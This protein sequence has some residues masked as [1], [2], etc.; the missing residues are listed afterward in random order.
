MNQQVNVTLTLWADAELTKD[1]VKSN[2]RDLIKF[3]TLHSKA[4]DRNLIPEITITDIKEESEIYKTEPGKRFPNGFNSWIE[5]SI[6]ISSD[7]H[8]AWDN[9]E[10]YIDGRG[11]L[12]ELVEKYTDEF[13]EEHVN[14]EWADQKLTW[15]DHLDTFT[16]SKIQELKNR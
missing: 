12:W 4:Y 13:E 6:E 5:T 11:E 2:I 8:K 9:D 3:A 16:T 15:F 14:T 10:I 1:Q 7:L